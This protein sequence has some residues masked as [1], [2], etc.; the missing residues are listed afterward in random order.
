MT[1]AAVFF[2]LAAVTA[3]PDPG[4]PGPEWSG[5]PLDEVLAA[6]AARFRGGEAAGLHYEAWSRVRD[7][8]R[9]G[10]LTVL[11]SSATRDAVQPVANE[12]GVDAVVCR[13]LRCDAT[14]TYFGP[15][16]PTK[17]LG[18]S[19]RAFAKEHKL[20]LTQCEAY[21]ARQSDPTLADAVGRTTVLDCVDRRAGRVGATRTAATYAAFLGSAGI[22]LM[23][24]VASGSRRRGADAMS[25]SFAVVGPL[26]SGIEIDVQGE[27]HLRAE[28]PA[29]F[30]INH[31]S[32]LVDAIV[33]F[34]LLRS[35][36]RPVAK[37]EVR[38][39]PLLGTAT[40]LADWAYVERVGDRTT[41]VQA[42]ADGVA[43]L[44][45][46][47]SV[48]MAPEGTRS[49]GP[50]PGPFKKGGFYMAREAEVP[51]IP[52]VMRNSGELMWRNGRALKAGT[53]DVCVLPP[54]RCDWSDQEFGQ[55]VDEVRQMFVD[56]LE[57]WPKP[58]TSQ[59][60]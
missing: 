17:S 33:T 49:V 25:R 13:E 39:V 18:D 16:P 32:S 14:G 15:R 9:R 55:N 36:F 48:I 41:A 35:G 54:I 8:R 38:D 10:A 56:V 21:V 1:N 2:D 3:S 24:G 44:R 50:T 59:R 20:A 7:E 6:G 4:P 57:D 26:T 27:D 30:M 19:V 58:E 34:R 37:K 45:E 47:V 53:V 11:V 43:K 23:A 42:V 28:R 46:G 31:Q 51:V 29:V 5:R 40:W 12:L 60:T 52:I 22:G